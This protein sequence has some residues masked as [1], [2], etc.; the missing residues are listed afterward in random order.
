MI[1]I[2][3]LVFVPKGNQKAQLSLSTNIAKKGTKVKP[4]NPKASEKKIEFNRK[5]RSKYMPRR[6]HPSKMG[7][8]VPAIYRRRP[9]RPR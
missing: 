9:I 6:L 5:F 4:L 3:E 8:K 1:S 2:L 7:Y